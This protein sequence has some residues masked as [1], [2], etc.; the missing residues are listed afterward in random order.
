MNSCCINSKFAF[1]VG[2]VIIQLYATSIIVCKHSFVEK[3]VA[4]LHFFSKEFKEKKPSFSIFLVI[5]RK[6]KNEFCLRKIAK[7]L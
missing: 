1:V 7:A 6:I 5:L 3:K 4:I 2:K